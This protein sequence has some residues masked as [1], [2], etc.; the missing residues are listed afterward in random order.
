MPQTLQWLSN[1]STTT[2]YI[3]TGPYS[4]CTAFYGGCDVTLSTS[5]AVVLLL[6]TAG[7]P[8][9]LID[10][11]CPWGTQHSSKPDACHCYCRSMGQRD[12]QTDIRPLR[13]PCSEYYA[14]SANKSNVNYQ[15]P[16]ATRKQH[17]QSHVRRCLF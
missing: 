12:R 6:L 5:A 2:T 1:G 16:A 8:P 13:R 9:L 7:R 14:N 10:I 4:L 15:L 17:H 3:Q 11:S